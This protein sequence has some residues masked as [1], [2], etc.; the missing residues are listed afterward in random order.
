MRVPPIGSAPSARISLL[1]KKRVSITLTTSSARLLRPRDGGHF[2]KT[3]S[4]SCDECGARI[5][6]QPRL[7]RRQEGSGAG[8]VGRL[9]CG[10]YQPLL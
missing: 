2:D 7:P 3:T 4:S 10:V 6:G 8:C 1:L 5:L 9:Q